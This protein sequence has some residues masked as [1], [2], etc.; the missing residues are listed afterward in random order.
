MAVLSMA[1]DNVGATRANRGLLLPFGSS[2]PCMPLWVLAEREL[3]ALLTV[4]IT[5]AIEMESMMFQGTKRNVRRR[6]SLRTGRK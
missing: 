2:L 3:A 5:V 6:N 4:A 1:V